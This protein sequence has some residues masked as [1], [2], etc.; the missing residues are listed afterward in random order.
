MILERILI[1]TFSYLKTLLLSPLTR[2]KTKKIKLFVLKEKCLSYVHRQIQ[3]FLNHNFF[4]RSYY[5]NSFKL[6]L[7]D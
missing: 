4:I 6:Y 1:K 5:I 7:S 3:K 2:N